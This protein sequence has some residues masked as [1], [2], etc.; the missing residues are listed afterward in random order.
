[1]MSTYQPKLSQPSPSQPNPSQYSLPQQTW[2]SQQ[3]VGLSQNDYHVRSSR[4]LAVA[5]RWKSL[6]IDDTYIWGTI[7]LKNT[8]GTISIQATTTNKTTSATVAK[9]VTGS[10]KTAA[11]KSKQV[12]Q[13]AIRLEDFQSSCTCVSHHSPCQHAM[14]L[15]FMLDD[16]NYSGNNIFS[17]K[18][19]P[20]W[21]KEAFTDVPEQRFGDNN[22]AITNQE[23]VTSK[24]EVIAQGLAE[25]ELWL[26]DLLRGGLNRFKDKP[27][28]YT[29]AMSHRLID[30]DLQA[31]ARDINKF[32]L[33]PKQHMFKRHAA[34][35]SNWP[36]LLLAEIG[37]IYALIQAFKRLDD[38]PKAVQG[39]VYM[40]LGWPQV[41]ATSQSI[42]DNWYILGKAV[43]QQGKLKEQR[44]WL[45]GKQSHK[46]AFITRRYKAN[47]RLNQHL[48]TGTTLD[49]EL[50]FYNSQHPL[51]AEVSN[52]ATATVSSTEASPHL[53]FSS[54]AIA[55]EKF[56][57]AKAQ[58]PWLRQ[59]P[60][61]LGNVAPSR[62]QSK[63]AKSK[64][65]V[66]TWTIHDQAGYQL[67]VVR[68]FKY[69]WHLMALG[70]SDQLN[71]LA[72]WNGY[73][74]KP[75]SLKQD[76]HMHDIQSFRG[77]S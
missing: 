8:A 36:E 33:I 59:F 21:L 69:G 26:S 63:I 3:I 10:T 38:L 62:E 45:Y 54:I 50:Q 44:T 46:L 30:S 48:L 65:K 75:V 64:S 24:H 15:L 23:L 53:E 2:T 72:E 52:Q 16:V 18:S 7:T 27:H 66:D 6:A 51:K 32:A 67:P 47:E 71:F 41:D 14:A 70:L 35:S 40:A 58:N 42:S 56:R 57:K 73:D 22:T 20:D 12:I 60:M 4:S 74:L 37:R 39:D 5:S 31:L 29:N 13:T 25:L 68:N 77:L 28:D 61:F 1:M 9:P 55:H 49:A 43:E 11:N 19:Q 76:E 17:A 34:Q